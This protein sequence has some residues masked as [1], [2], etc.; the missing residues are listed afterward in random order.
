MEDHVIEFLLDRR[1]DKFVRKYFQLAKVNGEHENPCYSRQI[2][3]II[4]SN[5]FNKILATGYN[6]PPRG[7]PHCN[8]ID[9]YRNIF[10]P[11]LTENDKLS[12]AVYMNERIFDEEKF[13]SKYAGA[14]ICPRKL[15]KCNSGEKLNLCTCVH[16]E[17]NAV[18]NS[19]CDLKNS[20][21]FAWCPLPCIE[22][23]KVIINAG[24]KKLFCYR[25]D[26]DYSIVSRYLLKKCQVDVYEL[27][28][29]DFI[30]KIYS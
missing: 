14:K 6:G 18:V 20:Y 19:N 16:A 1:N 3:V 30:T 15:L 23:S 28:K 2:G 11:Q 8:S 25:E 24:I 5:D 22:C 17:V 9:H 10:L 29:E 13:V 27:E 7:A 21:M 4:V 12:L 26:K